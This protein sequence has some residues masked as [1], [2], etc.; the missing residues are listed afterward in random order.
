MERGPK[1]SEREKHVGRCPSFKKKDHSH[2]VPLCPDKGLPHNRLSTTL[3]HFG[4]TLLKWQPTRVCRKQVSSF[5][6]R[7][8][9]RVVGTV[10]Q[11]TATLPK[12]EEAHLNLAVASLDLWCVG[13]SCESAAHLARVEIMLIIA[14]GKEIR[15]V[16]RGFMGALM[17]PGSASPST[18]SRVVSSSSPGSANSQIPPAGSQ[19]C[20][21]LPPY[22][23]R[24]AGQR[25]GFIDLPVVLIIR[26]RTKDGCQPAIARDI[27]SRLTAA[28]LFF[29]GSP[30]AAC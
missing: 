16:S 23:T 17:T 29:I 6:R 7:L 10:S 9:V 28:R 20:V 12:K 15:H 27:G 24:S 18:M 13:Q 8:A 4:Q 21:F 11:R 3:R 14:F 1:P 2:E 30:A 19:W 5:C 22:R 26:G 25:S